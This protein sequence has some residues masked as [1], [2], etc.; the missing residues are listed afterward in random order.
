[1]LSAVEGLRS[2]SL[3]LD[4]LIVPITLILLSFLFWIQ[5]YGTAFVG[6]IFA[7]VMLVWFI[8]IALAGAWQIAAHPQALA[9][10]SPLPAIAFFASQPLVAFLSMGAVILVVTGAEALYADMGHFGRRPIARAWFLLVFPALILCYMGQ[11]AVLLQ[12]PSATLSPFMALFPDSLRIPVVILATAAALIASQSVISGAFSLTRQ[13][14]QLD[15]L[16]KMR[17]VHTSLREAGQIYLPFINALLFGAVVF[18][19]MVFGSSAR[20]ANAYGIAVSGT[21]AIDTILFLVV[22]RAVWRKPLGLVLAGALMF[23]TTDLL[24]VAASLPKILE[25]GWLPVA[26]AGMVLLLILTWYAGQRIV[27]AERRALEGSLQDFIDRIRRAR[28]AVKRV[29]GCAVYIGH[30]ASLA[31]LALHAAVEKLHVLHERVVIVTVRVTTAAH[32]PEHQRAEFDSLAYDDGISHL[33]LSYGFHDSPNIPRTLASLR[34]LSP[35]LDFDPATAAYFISLSKVVP[36]RRPNLG[37]WRK[38]LYIMMAR[39]A[40]STSDYYKLP[41]ERTIEMRTLIEL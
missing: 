17:V 4:R 25:S 24:F 38:A 15:F 11:G 8:T 39:N 16:P 31:P 20:L 14:I 10:L 41:P 21:L 27:S 33:R 29:P 35:E 37:S 30:H 12:Q 1:V 9:A 7:P 2:V 18:L 34:G 3:D 26:L 32:I 5:R 36:S 19:V 13:A 6:R 23:V 22:A 40:L 28:P